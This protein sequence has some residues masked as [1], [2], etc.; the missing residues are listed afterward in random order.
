MPATETVRKM[1]N[2]SFA[3]DSKPRK[4]APKGEGARILANRCRVPKTC[5]VCG[6]SPTLRIAGKKEYCIAHVEDSFIEMAKIGYKI[7]S[8]Q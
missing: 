6:S 4:S 3:L 2:E 1:D 8:A 5:H 7:S